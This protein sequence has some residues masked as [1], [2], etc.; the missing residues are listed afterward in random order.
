[1]E[2]QLPTFSTEIVTAQFLYRGKLQPRGELFTFL[3]DRRYLN[4]HMREATFHPLPE[5]YRVNTL[6]QD[7]INV[8][9]RDI[10]YIALLHEANMERVQLLQS[11][12]PVTF[13]LQN[14]AIRGNLRVNPDAHD[15]DLLDETRDFL[16][17]T[18]ANIV[19]LHPVA[20]VPA[21]TVPLLA[22]NRHQIESY[23]VYQPKA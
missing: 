1:M 18:D 12:R 10:L 23:H 15:N 8:N 17:V 16:A 4:F 2:L 20:A 22:L 11:G 13:Y 7:G 6:K 19:P 5:G 9:W 14:L 3:N 21:S